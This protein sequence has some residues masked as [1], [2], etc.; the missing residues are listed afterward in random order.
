MV[1]FPNGKINIGLQITGKRPDGF[2]DLETIFYP[3]QLFDVLEIN[4]ADKFS[5]Q[6]T[7]IKIEDITD[8]IC[9]KAYNVLKNDFN[10]PTVNIQLHKNIPVGAGLGGG[11]ADAVGCL[12]LLNKKFAL[13]LSNQ[14]LFGYAVSLGSDCSFFL[15]NQPCF[16]TGRGENL[17]SIDLDL[18]AYRILLVNP[19]IAVNT[20][21]AFSQVKTF[22]KTSNLV[23]LVKQTPEHWKENVTNDFEANIFASYPSIKEIKDQLYHQGAMYAAM[24]G[25]G[26]SVYG[27][28]TKDAE[29]QP[30]FPDNYYFRW[31]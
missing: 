4:A 7:G 24:S 6:C 27:I 23:E 21:W 2:H 12:V 14:Q 31:V 1:A 30:I 15:T 13:N 22:S 16:A 26:S 20:G 25:S 18:S 11:S 28:F 8:N 9:L 5:F 29:V 19:G 3:I 17:Q 10:L